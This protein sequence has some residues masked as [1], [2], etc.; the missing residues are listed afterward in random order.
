MPSSDLPLTR[1]QALAAGAGGVALLFAGPLRGGAAGDVAEAASATCVMTPEKTEGP[2]FV[3]EALNRSDIRASKDGSGLQ[4]GAPLALTMYVFDATADCARSPAHRST[5][6]TRTRRR[7]LRRRPERHQRADLAARVPGHR[8]R[9]QGDVPDDLAGLVPRPRGAHPLQGPRERP[10]VH[11]TAVLHRR[12]ERAGVRERAVQR[13]RDRRHARH[14][15]RHLRDGRQLAAAPSHVRRRG[16]LPRGLLGRRRRRRGRQRRRRRRGHRDRRHPPLAARPPHRRRPGRPRPPARR[17][18]ADR[19]RAAVARRPDPRAPQP[20]AARR[21]AHPAAADRDGHAGGRRAAHA[22]L[23]DAAGN[24]RVIR[25][26]VH[27]PRRR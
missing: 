14:R 6:G 18:A 3:D 15:R 17:R 21:Q 24:R 1:R 5:S 13:P 12:D 10:R 26:T 16:R 27:V 23:S 8:R 22:R 20:H 4:P 11:L 7:V 25:R 19:P 2:Y 9:R